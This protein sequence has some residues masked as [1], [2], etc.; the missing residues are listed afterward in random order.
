[1]KTIFAALIAIFLF[2]CGESLK[3][4]DIPEDVLSS[5][6]SKFPDVK[7]V[8]WELDDKTYEVEF[9]QDDKEMSASLNESGEWEIKEIDHKSDEEDV[10]TIILTQPL[11]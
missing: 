5:F 8:E 4:T 10:E 7:N 6:N 9:M 2:S 1:M 11:R 3:S